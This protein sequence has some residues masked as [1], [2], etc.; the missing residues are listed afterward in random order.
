MPFFM[1]RSTAGKII[2][3]LALIC[4][5]ASAQAEIEPKTYPPDALLK[6]ILDFREPTGIR[7]RLLHVEQT[8]QI[9]WLE[10]AQVSV[11]SP[12]FQEDWKE[13][14][15]EWIIAVHPLNQSQF[16]T[17]QQIPKGTALEMVIQLDQEG[18]RRILFFQELSMLPK[19]DSTFSLP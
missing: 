15:N 5:T 4:W 12:L 6:G 1:N 17:L 14:P 18:S 10:W 11:D 13:V 7:G 16:Y 3:L 2:S 19:V 8:K 9:I